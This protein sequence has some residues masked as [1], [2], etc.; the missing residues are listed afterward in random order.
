MYSVNYIKTDNIPK[1]ITADDI[2]N[3]LAITTDGMAM[4]PYYIKNTSALI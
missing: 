4:N 2:K 1:F 3:S